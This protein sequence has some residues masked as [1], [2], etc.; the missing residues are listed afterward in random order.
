I[1]AFERTSTS[2]H[3]ERL[4][5]VSAVREFYSGQSLISVLDIGFATLYLA[6]IYFI[7]GDIVAVPLVVIAMLLVLVLLLGK[8]LRTALADQAADEDQHNN[9][10]IRVLSGV[11]TFK[12]LASE[13]LLLRRYDRLQ[14]RR[15]RSALNSERRTAALSEISAFL[16]QGAVVA[17]V[18]VGSLRVIDG[19]LTV[20]GLAACTLLV[21]RSIQPLQAALGFWTKFQNVSLS[22]ERIAE[23]FALP[24]SAESMAREGQGAGVML[25]ALTVR[26]LSYRYDDE[27]PWIFRDVNLQVAP[28]EIIAIAGPNGAGKTTLLSI[29]RGL[30]TPTQGEVLLDGTGIGDFSADQWRD[31]VAVLP[32]RE[33]LF[34]GTILENIT[35][36]ESELEPAALNAAHTLGF[37]AE[38]HALPEGFRTVLG[39]DAGLRISRGLAQRITIA[40]ALVRRPKLLLFD[41]ANTAVDIASDD[42]LKD[43]L[44]RLKG[45]CTVLIVSHRPSILWLADRVHDL[46]DGGFEEQGLAVEE[47]RRVAS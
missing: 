26:N 33:A 13:A 32:Q 10:M 21:G 11:R 15:A 44:G 6:T 37:A 19:A 4:N 34:H 2:T 14:D 45:V 17:T 30:L 20:G 9:F 36:F 39:E 40:R 18:C 42:F 3:L 38:V 41:D 31:G 1:G 35:M 8:D 27:Q 46:R 22:R 25:G 16:T 5:A 28:G 23:L 47:L 43:V 24:P 12:A 7:G 29:I